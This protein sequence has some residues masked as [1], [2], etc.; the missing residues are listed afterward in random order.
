MHMIK[1]LKKF[2]KDTSGNFGMLTALLIVPIVTVAGISVDITNAMR[3]KS[4]LARAADIAAVGAVSTQSACIVAAMTTGK[5]GALPECQKTA[6]N[7]FKGNYIQNVP[8]QAVTTTIAVSKNGGKFTSSVQFAA[9]IP[10]T[11][12]RIIGK[13]T[14]PV[15]GTATGNYD[16]TIYQNFYVLLDNSPSMGVAAT[17]S[18]VAT[19]VANT[20]DKCAF[21]CHIVSTSGVEDMNSYYNKA[22]KLGVTTRI[23]VV[24]QAAA[25]LM[26]TATATRQYTNQFGMAIY[27]FGTK[28]EALGLLEVQSQT[29]NLAIAKTKAATVGLMSIPYQGYDND[30]QTS[31]DSVF[32][33]LGK[34]MGKGGVG[35][36]ITDPQKILFFVSDGVGDSYKP[37]GCTKKLSGSRCMEPIDTSFCDKVKAQNVRIAVLY[38]TY[39]PLPTNGWYNTWIKPFQSEISTK[40]QACASPGLFFEVSPTQGISDAM[41]YLFLKVVNSPRLTT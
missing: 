18:D 30:Q 34:K 38:T 2:C 28:A 24:A 25:K 26:D 8:D 33:D 32:T 16:A 29:T 9:E 19:M 7:I 14:I 37:V 17:P 6:L 4:D 36:D 41:N 22:K 31:F 1:Y 27:S 15:A 40:M 12:L 39:L 11:F 20:S 35:A 13:T 5:D 10:T 23:D 21:A 3:V